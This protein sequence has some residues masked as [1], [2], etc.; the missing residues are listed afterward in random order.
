ME[1]GHEQVGG[2]DRP[3]WPVYPA[4]M[5]NKDRHVRILCRRNRQF[6]FQ[7]QPGMPAIRNAPPARFTGEYNFKEGLDETGVCRYISFR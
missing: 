1:G 6:K 3:H 2:A 5:S 4:K 7:I